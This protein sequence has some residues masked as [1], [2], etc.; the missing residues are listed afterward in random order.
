[1]A[2]FSSSLFGGSL[3]DIEGSINI[4]RE[5]GADSLH[6]DVMDGYFAEDFGFNVKSVRASLAFSGL[7]VDVHLMACMQ[8]RFIELFASEGISCLY[9]HSKGLCDVAPLL[10]R[11]GPPR[12]TGF[13]AGD[14]AGSGEGVAHA[15]R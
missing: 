15:V 14:A 13:I 7:P 10:R 12:G 9:I 2:E 1:M 5:A 3:L 11:I 6:M 4:A 8:E